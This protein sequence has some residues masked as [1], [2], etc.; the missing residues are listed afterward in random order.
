MYPNYT[1]GPF[2]FL[3]SYNHIHILIYRLKMSTPIK[4]EQKE[5]VTG[6]KYSEEGNASNKTGKRNNRHYLK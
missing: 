5:L 3:S 6:E 1:E 2:L 4:E